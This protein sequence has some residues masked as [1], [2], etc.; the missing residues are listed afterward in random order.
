MRFPI[1][2]LKVGWVITYNL[3]LYQDASKKEE[4]RYLINNSQ[5]KF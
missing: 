3:T 2:F 1:L 5:L 4:E